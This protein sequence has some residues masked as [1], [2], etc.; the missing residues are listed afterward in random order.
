MSNPVLY[1]PLLSMLVSVRIRSYLN[2]NDIRAPFAEVIDNP[3]SSLQ[4]S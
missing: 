1:I 2:F 3:S 4:G